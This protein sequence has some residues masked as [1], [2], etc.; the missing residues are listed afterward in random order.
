MQFIIFVIFEYFD[1]VAVFIGFANKIKIL[2][3]LTYPKTPVLQENNPPSY[4]FFSLVAL[5]EAEVAVVSKYRDYEF[6]DRKFS[7]R[8]S[9]DFQRIF[10]SVTENFRS[11]YQP[12]P[13]LVALWEAEVATRKGNGWYSEWQ[14]SLK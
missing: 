3:I 14:F 13:F 10:F 4:Q 8:K 5:W 1:I 12:L 9:S 11:S 6:S 2:M 7:D